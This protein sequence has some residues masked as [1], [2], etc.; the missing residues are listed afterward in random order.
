MKTIHFLSGIQRSGSTLLTKI[1]NQHPEVFA[2]STSPFFDYLVPASEKLHLIKR[3]HSS[4]HYVDI[5]HIL[6]ASVSAFYNFSEKPIVVDKHRGWSAN[7]E[8]I[9]EE[10][11]IDPK[12]IV[13]LRP[14]EEVVMSFYSILYKNGTPDTV[15]RIYQGYIKEHLEILKDSA[16]FASKFCVVTYQRLTQ[17]P[18]L[19]LRDVEAYLEIPHF[20]YNFNNIVDTD[21]ENDNKWGIK[22]L[23]T[24]RPSI[25]VKSLSPE[26][27]MTKSELGFCKEKTKEL[28]TAYG[29]T[30]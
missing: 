8:T 7:Y 17:D 19:T 30:F 10:L 23:H 15:S 14:I 4:G 24:I 28:Y 13:T 6:R 29:L 1:M 20:V 12:I 22:D 26:K 9:K 18:G 3:D 25:E 27:I 21:P 2:T 16:K 5:P 11:K